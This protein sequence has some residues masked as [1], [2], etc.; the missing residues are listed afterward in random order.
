MNMDLPEAGSFMRY[1]F[2]EQL[3]GIHKEELDLDTTIHL[4]ASIL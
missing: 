3:E 4:S 1:S 2:E